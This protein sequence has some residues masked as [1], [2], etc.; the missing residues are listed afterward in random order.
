MGLS[1][2]IERI[3]NELSEIGFQMMYGKSCKEWVLEQLQKE[4]DK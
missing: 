3:K 2:T 1:D 4:D